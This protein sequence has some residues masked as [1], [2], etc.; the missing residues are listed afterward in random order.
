MK[1]QPVPKLII[2]VLTLG[3]TLHSQAQVV[4]GNYDGCD[5]V[6]LKVRGTIT[7][8]GGVPIT[9]AKI[10]A[11]ENRRR[12]VSSIEFF[13]H[14]GN[15]LHLTQ[16]TT[17]ASSLSS[18]SQDP[19]FYEL[20]LI[21]CADDKGDFAADFDVC[22]EAPGFQS[23]CL[24]AEFDNSDDREGLDFMLTPS[25]KGSDEETL[26]EKGLPAGDCGGYDDC[27]MAL[28][29]VRGIVRDTNGTP[30]SNAVVTGILNQSNDIN[31]IQFYDHCSE[32]QHAL[33]IEK[34][35]VS[36]SGDSTQAGFYELLFSVCVEDNNDILP[37]E[38]DVDIDVCVTAPGFE[39]QC[40]V[41]GFDEEDDRDDRDFALVAVVGP[42]ETPTPSPTA[43]LTEVTLPTAIN[44]NADVNDDGVINHK[45]L[46]IL[47][48]NWLRVVH[49]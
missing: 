3:W 46:L 7:D 41:A 47:L 9:T 10:T 16:E 43:T 48:E 38:F 18:S 44:P 35:S 39:G 31:A 6:I 49:Q 25:P 32:G 15:G 2:L 33:R 30:I 24:L 1:I 26:E 17:T 40:T 5:P 8:L 4:C 29:K 12:D 23:A 13:E 42:T 34:T 11:T 14:C 21:V 28:L 37:D 27:A 22:V 19:G 36:Q 20:L 45:D